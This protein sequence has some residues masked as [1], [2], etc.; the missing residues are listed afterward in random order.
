MTKTT[1]R[2]PQTFSFALYV[3]RKVKT[4]KRLPSA[5]ASKC[6]M[7]NISYHSRRLQTLGIIRKVSPRSG[8]YEV[9]VTES[10]AK[11]RL[12]INTKRKFVT[13]TKTTKGFLKY[14]RLH[15]VQVKLVLPKFD[16]WYNI[17]ET[18]LDKKELSYHLNKKGQYRLKLEYKGLVHTFLLC[19]NT[20]IFYLPNGRDFISNDLNLVVDLCKSYINGLLCAFSSYFGKDLRIKGVFKFD[21]TRKH[22][23]LM[24]NEIARDM[25]K[26]NKDIKV[27]VDGKL[28]V[29]TD[30]SFNFDELEA[31][32][33]DEAVSDTRSMELMI[34][35]VIMNNHTI[36]DVKDIV[37]NESNILNERM[38]TLTKANHELLDLI[39]GL[40]KSNKYL[41]EQHEKTANMQRFIN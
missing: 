21:I 38:K 24:N 27:W 20:I 37:I 13:T 39:E 6:S 41:L 29:I 22:I 25:H 4:L 26:R 28:R 40:Q 36:S 19:K 9:L 17:L 2:E 7:S 12:K 30:N 14:K 16:Y 33:N 34:K 5:K 23:A 3:Y 15:S 32:T 35:D 1:Q 10:E 31:I 8:I 11:R 18:Y